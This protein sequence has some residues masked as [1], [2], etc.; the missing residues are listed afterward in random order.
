MQICSCSTGL[1]E[2]IIVEIISFCLLK[3]FSLLCSTSK[4]KDLM[5]ILMYRKWFWVTCN[6]FY[7]FYLCRRDPLWW[8]SSS[9][10]NHAFHVSLCAFCVFLFSSF[11]GGGSSS[12]EL[13]SFSLSFALFLFCLSWSSAVS[14]YDVH[15]Y[16]KFLYAYGIS[17][18]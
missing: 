16:E 10:C 13:S 15:V 14:L 3:V 17:L 18:I 2:I 8:I 1:Y 9:P 7:E 5:D 6:D 11:C 4:E 12:C